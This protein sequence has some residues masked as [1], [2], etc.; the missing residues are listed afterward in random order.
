MLGRSQLAY[1]ILRWKQFLASEQMKYRKQ[2]I[3]LLPADWRLKPA[4]Q[5][6]VPKGG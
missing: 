2:R 1:K 5:E 6:L 3:N 4:P